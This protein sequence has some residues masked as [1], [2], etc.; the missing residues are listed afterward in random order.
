[1]ILG[2]SQQLSGFKLSFLSLWPLPLYLLV[3]ELDP[4]AHLS[5]QSHR[6]SLLGASVRLRGPLL[7]VLIQPIRA[8]DPSSLH[9]SSSCTGTSESHLLATVATVAEVRRLIQSSFPP[10]PSFP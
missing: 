6:Q 10:I 9:T 5:S 2:E 4:L 8:Q 3:V 7:G 1:M